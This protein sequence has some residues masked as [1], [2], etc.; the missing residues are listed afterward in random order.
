MIGRSNS[1]LFNVR[2]LDGR[3]NE[4]MESVKAVTELK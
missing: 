4:L 1:W 3:I 2:D